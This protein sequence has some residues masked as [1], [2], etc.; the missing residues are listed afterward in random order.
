MNED[1]QLTALREAVGSLAAAG[2]RCALIGGMAVGA[3]A[4]VPRATIDVDLAVG[5]AVPRD[6]V[7]AALVAAG[8]ERRGEHLHTLNFRH[9]NGEP[10][11]VA[12]DP[13]FDPVVDRADPVTVGGVEVPV[14][15]RSDLVAMKQ[16]AAQDP[17]RR[18]SKALRDL[19]DVELLRGDVAD[20]GEGW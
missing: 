20:E 15:L 11:R 10:V 17:S 2:I 16:R 7:T 3:R 14:A 4:G 19:A 18:R 8:F 6:E 1:D 5:T 9:R 13:G 12:F